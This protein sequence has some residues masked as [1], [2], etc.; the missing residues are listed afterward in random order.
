MGL[1]TFATRYFE[2]QRAHEIATIERF[3]GQISLAPHRL[4]LITVVTKQDLW[5]GE[6]QKVR[7]FYESGRYAEVVTSIRNQLGSQNFSHKIGSASLLYRNLVD[8][9]GNVLRP[10]TS[11]YDDEIKLRHEHALLELIRTEAARE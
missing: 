1:E 9:D 3:A 10:T 7:S 2:E 5:W 11:G 6:R 4:S 8:R